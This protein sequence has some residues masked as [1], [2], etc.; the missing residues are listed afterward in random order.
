MRTKFVP[1]RTNNSDY[2][3]EERTESADLREDNEL[4]RIVA[5]GLIPYLMWMD[6]FIDFQT[7]GDHPLSSDYEATQPDFREYYDLKLKLF[8]Q[9]WKRSKGSIMRL[10][11]QE[12]ESD[13]RDRHEARERIEFEALPDDLKQEYGSRFGEYMSWLNPT[14]DQA[15]EERKLSRRAQAI[16]ILLCDEREKGRYK[17]SKSD[18]I[19]FAST[20]WRLTLQQ[21]RGVYEAFRSLQVEKMEIIKQV[22]LQDYDVALSHFCEDFPEEKPPS[23]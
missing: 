21:A 18:V 4:V 1:V 5:H 20:Q 9:E 22:Y 13:F 17:N 15:R 16:Y 12:F 11:E 3:L 8:K 14:L 7:K 6:S 19:D 23:N 2:A 10:T